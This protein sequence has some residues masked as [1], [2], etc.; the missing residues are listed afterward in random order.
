MKKW[1]NTMLA[2]VVIGLLG[3]VVGFLL[4]GA[5]FCIS[6]NVN[7]EYFYVNVYSNFPFFKTK[8]S[9]VAIMFDVLPFYLFMR[10]EYYKTAQ[11]ILGVI[12][13]AVI[14]TIFLYE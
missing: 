9:T 11:G 12:I 2:G 14:V 13:L 1:L 10:K 4:F 7:F 3:L 8:I 6:N 5:Y